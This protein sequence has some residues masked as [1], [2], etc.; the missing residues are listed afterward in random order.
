VV[1]SGCLL[2][3][4]ISEQDLAAVESAIAKFHKQQA[5]G[6]DVDIY[7]AASRE[8]KGATTVA[9]LAQLNDAVRM[10]EGCTPPTRDKLNYSSRVSTSGSFV[11]LSYVRTC[12]R[13]PIVEQFLMRLGEGG[14]E[15]EGY[16]LGGEAILAPPQS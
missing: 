14:P 8:F 2:A 6:H 12:T 1:A 7:R 16:H 9:G 11:T 15:L 3:A 5:A 13:G 10:A 4:C